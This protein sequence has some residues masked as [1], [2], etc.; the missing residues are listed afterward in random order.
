ML[1][2]TIGYYWNHC[3]NWKYLFHFINAHPTGTRSGDGVDVFD[4][5]RIRSRSDF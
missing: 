3:C 2:K 5:N 4:C 1:M